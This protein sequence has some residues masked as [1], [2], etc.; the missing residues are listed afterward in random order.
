MLQ[1]FSF[2]VI[3]A[4]VI[5][6]F[7]GI[8]MSLFITVVNYRTWVKNHGIS[9]S[10]RILFSLGITRFLTLGLLLLSTIYFISPNV[11][12][13]VYLSAFF[14]LC[15]M[16]LDSSSLWF[17][18]LLNILYCVKISNFQHSVFLMLK[19]NISPKISR[20]LLICVLISAFTTLLYVVLSQTSPF[21]E[22]V[23]RRN[24]TLFDMNEGILCLVA[25]FFLSSF[26]QFIINVTSAS[27]LIHSLRRHIQKMQKN[28]TVFWH[29]QTEA[30]VGA[31]KLM[32]YFLILYIPYSIATL[33]HFLPSYV[34]MGLGVRSI[35]R[36]IATLYP[37]VHSFLIIF[38]HPKLKTKARKI[39]CFNK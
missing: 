23:T 24:G 1:V 37:S 21:P 13:S 18:T 27:L 12:R 26:I 5:F 9:S 36:I 34:G 6:N 4:S 38:T 19:R 39:L 17:V 28:A 14:L 16:F 29:P 7:V 15:W 20:L 10:D 33:I 22:L 2:S 11:E 32:I 30:H 8:I 31:M 3:T 35:C 25:S